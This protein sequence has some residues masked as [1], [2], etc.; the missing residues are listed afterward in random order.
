V[1]LTGVLICRRWVLFT[2]VMFY[3][4]TNYL[5]WINIEIFFLSWHNQSF[6]DWS[7]AKISMH[8]IEFLFSWFYF[9]RVFLN[10]KEIIM[11]KLFFLIIDHIST[12]H[13]HFINVLKPFLSTQLFTYKKFLRV[14]WLIFYPSDKDL[15]YSE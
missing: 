10:Y 1:C 12:C 2:A 5:N 15:F 14:K 8:F 9:Q 13:A 4:S 7:Y 11:F 3:L 6:F